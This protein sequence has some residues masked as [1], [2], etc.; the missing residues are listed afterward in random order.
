MKVKEIIC[1]SNIHAFWG[2]QVLSVGM[3][4]TAFGTTYSRP[5]YANW[6]LELT[7][8]GKRKQNFLPSSIALTA[9]SLV[10]LRCFTIHCSDTYQK[11]LALWN[12]RVK[13][14]LTLDNR[15][16]SLR[17]QDIRVRGNT[18]IQPWNQIKMKMAKLLENSSN[19]VQHS[20]FINLK[21]T[22]RAKTSVRAI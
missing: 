14:W 21:S 4:A 11:R 5:K 7:D 1:Q 12:N 10:G 2:C 20:N 16:N 18:K 9:V 8:G 6:Q 15:F 17:V 22:Q 13:G 3:R 19:F